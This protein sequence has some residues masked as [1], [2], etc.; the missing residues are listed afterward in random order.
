MDSKKMMKQMM[1]VHK[2]SLKNGFS[3]MALFQNQ[4]EKLMK[5]LI[6]LTFGISDEGKKVFDQWTDASKKGFDDLVKA[7]DD[8][9]EKIEELI[10]SSAMAMFHEQT[11][12]MFDA[13]W[14]QKTWMP[15][16][17]KKTLE[18]LTAVYTKGC[19]EFKN[20]WMRT[21]SIWEIFMLLQEKHR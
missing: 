9:Y 3:T 12:K 11:E 16:D 14:N 8:G 1:D 20:I 17:L 18:E 6:D 10:N 19:E 7:V 2:T 15:V 4:T 21:S 5:I 13:F